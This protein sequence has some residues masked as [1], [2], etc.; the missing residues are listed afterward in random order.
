MSKTRLRWGISY[1]FQKYFRRLPDNRHEW[2]HGES[3]WF[4]KRCGVCVTGARSLTKC[5]LCCGCDAFRSI[6][7]TISGGICIS[8]I[9]WLSNNGVKCWVWISCCSDGWTDIIIWPFPHVAI[10]PQ[11]FRQIMK[12]KE[13]NTTQYIKCFEAVCERFYQDFFFLT[14]FILFLRFQ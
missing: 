10:Y 7:A 14:F 3:A 13:S 9:F 11:E 12:Q 5:I 8:A 6:E 2:A 1:I 4:S